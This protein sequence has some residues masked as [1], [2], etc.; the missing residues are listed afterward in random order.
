MEEKE[1]FD[2]RSNYTIKADGEYTVIEYKERD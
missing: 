1:I 2:D